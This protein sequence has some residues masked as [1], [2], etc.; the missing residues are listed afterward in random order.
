MK[1]SRKL[2]FQV[3]Y[4]PFKTFQFFF[5]LKSKALETEA[6][7][8]SSMCHYEKAHLQQKG[9]FEVVFK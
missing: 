6:D 8:I 9:A 5:P 1:E 7:L 3:Y 2:K 4:R